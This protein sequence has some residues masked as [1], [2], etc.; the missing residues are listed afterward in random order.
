[1]FLLPGGDGVGYRLVS[2]EIT[3]VAR[4]LPVDRSDD[5]VL[6]PTVSALLDD[7]EGAAALQQFAIGVV[8]LT[9]DADPGLTRAL[10]SADGMTRLVARDGWNYWRVTASGAENTRPVAP[11]R[12]QLSDGT[13]H[14]T[15]LVPTTGIHAATTTTLTVTGDDTRLTVAEGQGWSAHAQV[16]WLGQVVAPEPGERAVYRLT[17][18]EGTL[19]IS[20]IDPHHGWR[21]LQFAL[22]GIVLFLAIP[23]GSRA[24]RSRS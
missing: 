13:G 20:L 7:G 23:F 24:S 16:T 6:A 21:L 15:V 14:S 22:L 19:E 10:D 3:D 11:P 17:P 8:A 5:A 1:M 18:G 12:L 4:S 9:E 2:R